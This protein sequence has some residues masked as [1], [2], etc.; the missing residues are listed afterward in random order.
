MSGTH[1]HTI[2][3]NGVEIFY[4]E[5]G[6]ANAPVVLLLHG[7]PSSSFQ[8]RNLITK[9]EGKYRVIAPDLPGFGFTKVPDALKYQYTFYNIAKTIEAFVD[10]L[11]LKNY[12]IYIFDYGAPTG[13]RLALSRP[14]AITAII[15]QNGNAFEVGLGEFW[16]GIRKYW[17]DPTPYNRKSLVWLTKF[18]ATK[19]Q[20]EAGEAHPE[21][22]PPETYHLDQAL[23]DRPGN[24]DI[25]LDLQLNYQTNVALYPAFHDYFRNY[26][27]PLLAIWGANDDIFVPAGA[28][29][30]KTVLPN[31]QIHFVDGGHFALENHLDEISA[32][33]IS[34]LENIGV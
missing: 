25:Q 15:S 28:E 27:P 26:Q 24:A 6:K 1:V 4:R 31:A 10:V 11:N 30:F 34:F 23:M 12:A 16:N 5:A 17:N 33:I 22:I 19:F 14:S 13:L 7:F 21:T 8:Y 3:V 9:L 18:E 29:A 2:N 32:H 20:Y